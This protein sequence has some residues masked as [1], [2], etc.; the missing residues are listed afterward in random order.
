MTQTH[1]DLFRIDAV[2]HPRAGD[3]TSAVQAGSRIASPF[4]ALR[5]SLIIE[6]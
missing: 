5:Y 3:G 4:A 6:R 1:S 2:R